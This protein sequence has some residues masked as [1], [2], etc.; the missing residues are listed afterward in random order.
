MNY[1]IILSGGIGTRME[2]GDFPKQYFEIQGKMILEYTLDRFQNAQEVDAIVVVMAEH[3]W[4]KLREKLCSQYSKLIGYAK[5]GSNR[6]ESILSGLKFCMARSGSEDDIVIIHDGVRPLVTVDLIGKCFEAIREYEGCLPVIPAS[7]TIYYSE[8]GKGL[9][10]LM[11]RSRLYMGQSPE[12]FLLH[13]YY[14]AHDGKDREFLSRMRGTTEI[15][16]AAGMKIC[17][18]PGETLN[19]KIT[20]KADLRRFRLLVEDSSGDGFKDNYQYFNPDAL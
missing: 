11:D 15:A 1:A 14:M 16:Y 7:D 5:P 6:Q 9:N 3:W 17:L 4:E 20:T 2:M 13:K 12:A 19:F 10:K 18:L 8:D